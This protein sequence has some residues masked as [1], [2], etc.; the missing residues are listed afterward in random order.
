MS[1]P[2]IA[3]ATMATTRLAPRSPSASPPEGSQL[4]AWA[5]MRPAATMSAKASPTRTA[6]SGR[7]ATTPAPNQAPTTAAPIIDTRVSGSTSM[8]VTARMACAKVGKQ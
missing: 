3:L 5:I 4:R 7:R 6:R 8:K 2:R 1:A